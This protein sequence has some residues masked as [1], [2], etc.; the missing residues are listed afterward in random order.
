M[1]FPS[2]SDLS[3]EQLD[4]YG[5]DNNIPLL[6]KGGPGSGKTVMALWRSNNLIQNSKK[7]SL[8]MY[9]NTLLEFT[10]PYMQNIIEESESDTNLLQITTVDKFLINKYSKYHIVFPKFL[11][12]EKK[13]L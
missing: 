2:F 6:I 3:E 1:S 11:S 5:F 8:L 4:V 10:S 12:L 9:N 7:V 13:L